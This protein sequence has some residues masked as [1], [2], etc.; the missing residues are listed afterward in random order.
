M[1]SNE[2]EKRCPLCAEDMDWTDQ[3]F[4]PCK[5]GY[6]ICVWCWHHII[7]MAEKDQTERRCPACRTIYEKEKIVAMQANC[8]RTM[9]KISSKKTKPPKPK[10]KANE[11][12]KD[13]T[14]VRVMQRKMAYL[15]ELYLV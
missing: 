7:D 14:N 5:C 15:I 13:L 2:E 6:Q 3:Q 10:P 11:V 1:M 9:A 12:K 4:M 8:K